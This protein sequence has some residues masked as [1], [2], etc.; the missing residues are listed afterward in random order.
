MGRMPDARAPVMKKIIFNGK[1]LSEKMTGVS[2][3]AEELIRA[4]DRLRSEGHPLSNMPFELVRPARSRKSLS[5]KTIV[6]R[7]EGSL[8][9]T[10]WEQ[11]TLPRIARGSVLVNLCNLAPLQRRGDLVMIHDV[12]ARTSPESYT[13]AFVAWYRWALPILGRRSARVLTVSEH[14]RQTMSGYGIA[15]TAKISVIPNGVDHILRHEPDA[16]AVD[17]LQLKPQGFVLS[18]ATAQRHKNIALLCRAF[19]DPRMAHLEL[20]LFGAGSAAEFG[21]QGIAMPANVVFAGSINDSELRG[22][23]EAS[24][25]YA[26]PSLTEGFGLPPLE[27]M[28]AGSPAVV[29]NV[30]A[31]PATCG[32][33]ALYAA[34]D[35]PDAWVDAIL[36]YDK[37]PELRRRRIADGRQH[38]SQ[39]TWARSAM[40]L[41]THIGE[42]AQLST[43]AAASGLGA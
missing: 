17:R 33:S 7:V 21:Q 6:E 22:L 23:M 9:R 18:Q 36:S 34:P 42:V 2:R 1:F 3:V 29:A 39:F 12:Q 30:G 14:S 28:L 16:G 27:S 38:A 4:T 41:L 31:L 26:C 8:P 25:C 13:R 19:T 5:L 24:L 20:V 15:P 37:N 40:M 32:S 11:V 35:D 10:A 43:S